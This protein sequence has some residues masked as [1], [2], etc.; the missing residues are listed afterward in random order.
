MNHGTLIILW[1]IS[2]VFIIGAT[3]IGVNLGQMQQREHITKTY[4]DGSFV[5]C[6]K[7]SKCDER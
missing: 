4:E 1:V 7:G 6:Y 2:V 5:G 3:L